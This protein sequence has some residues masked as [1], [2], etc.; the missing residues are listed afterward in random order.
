MPLDPH[1]K[2]LLDVLAMAGPAAP[3]RMTTSQRRRAFADLM[4]FSESD[5][6]IGHVADRVLPGPDG[7]IGIRVYTPSGSESGRL[8]GLVYFHGGGFVAGSLDTHEGLCR[9]LANEIGCRLV[10]VDYRLAPESKFPAAVT[11]GYAALRWTIEQA[12]ALE[13]NPDRIA[14]GGD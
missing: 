1:A 4:R 12:A 11:D 3:A 13:I 2:R 7:P 5:V 10:S 8:P 14:V 9:T 6:P